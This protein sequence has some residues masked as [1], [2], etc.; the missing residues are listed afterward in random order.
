MAF[1]ISV[2]VAGPVACHLLMGL[3]TMKYWTIKWV[4][5][6]RSSFTVS[7]HYP[8]LFNH[9][10][11]DLPHLLIGWLGRWLWG[12]RELYKSRKLLFSVLLRCLLLGFKQYLP[13]ISQPPDRHSVKERRDQNTIF[14]AGRGS[15]GGCGLDVGSIG[16]MVWTWASVHAHTSH[17]QP[18]CP[19][20]SLYECWDWWW[21]W[22]SQVDICK[23]DNSLLLSER[24]EQ[25]GAERHVKAG[26]FVGKSFY[27]ET[28]R[29]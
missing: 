13:P 1:K 28:R 23:G 21:Q 17:G 14:I 8:V 15:S 24:M 16:F 25:G 26:K 9:R 3:P 4:S 18:G 22:Q 11:L 10:C 6:Y 5:Q 20:T 29:C 7:L 19:G 2:S 27:L 12:S